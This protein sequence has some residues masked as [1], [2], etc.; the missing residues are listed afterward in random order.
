MI[1][2]K[3]DSETPKQ[4]P[5]GFSDIFGVKQ[6]QAAIDKR[7][8]K[9][10][11]KASD[12]VRRMGEDRKADPNYRGMNEPGAAKKQ[13]AQPDPNLQIGEDGSEWRLQDN[14]WTK[15]KEGKPKTA[16]ELMVEANRE[17]EA[18]RFKNAGIG[19]KQPEP[20]SSY[21]TPMAIA[22]PPAGPGVSSFDH[23]PH[24]RT[25]VIPPS[26][27]AEEPGEAGEAGEVLQWAFKVTVVPTGE[28][29]AEIHVAGGRRRVIGKT[30]WEIV[31][32]PNPYVFSYDEELVV[33]MIRVMPV[34]E[35]I[36]DLYVETAPGY[37][38]N[39][40]VAIGDPDSISTGP[41]NVV[42]IA[43]VS[44]DGQVIHEHFGNIEVID[45]KECE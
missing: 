21:K 42:R 8:K 25:T 14:K 11:D 2:N 13:P 7:R 6:L 34:F 10:E 22:I 30:G 26:K 41:S 44:D 3:P 37:W 27:P 31:N 39:S 38:H 23:G 20:P 17:K 9:A 29:T 33:F 36:D 19:P 15:T 43:T 24:S 40:G 28:G 4:K 5:W 16:S 12:R 32:P 45:L 35:T 1:S 18:E